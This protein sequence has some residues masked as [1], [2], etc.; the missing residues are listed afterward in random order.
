MDSQFFFGVRRLVIYRVTIKE[1]DT[2]NVVTYR[3]SIL[4]VCAKF[5]TQSVVAFVIL[6]L[7]VLSTSS[8]SERTRSTV[9]SDTGGLPVLLPLHKQQVS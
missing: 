3:E 1:I 5:S 6:N 8:G 2:F 9:S 7:H 4:H